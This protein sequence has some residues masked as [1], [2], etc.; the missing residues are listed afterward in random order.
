MGLV[1]IILSLLGLPAVAII[2]GLGVV[3][4]SALRSTVILAIGSIF[5]SRLAR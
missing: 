3:S 1:A 5:L 2:L 4:Y